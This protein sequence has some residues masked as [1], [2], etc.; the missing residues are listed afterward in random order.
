MKKKQTLLLTMFLLVA[1]LT[2]AQTSPSANAAA[3]S[4]AQPLRRYDPQM[5]NVEKKSGEDTWYVNIEKAISPATEQALIG[6]F[7]GQ[8]KPVAMG[9][10]IYKAPVADNLYFVL[11]TVR[12]DK[13][14]EDSE[15]INVFLALRE[16]GGTVSEVSKAE[17]ENDS[18]LR[19][20]V[21]FYGQNK[22][23]AIVS[24]SAA[25]GSLAGHY[26]Y[27]YA[28][29]NFKPLGDIPVIDKLGMSGQVWVTN[30]RIEGTTAEYK[31]GNYYVTVRGKGTL[32]QT[33]GYDKYKKLAPP[34]SPVTF[35]YNGKEWR[36]V[37]TRRAGRK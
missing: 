25:D 36:T 16:Q 12:K 28:D 8:Y 37:A 20:P 22:V 4:Q 18:L 1:A 19:A 5:R 30:N 15:F 14:S 29:N 21:F 17:N 32:Y 10:D 3:N 27:E 31:N 2:V 24:F 6:Y 11:G 7:T 35:S 13:Q 26:A 33:F 34:R 23:L 9:I